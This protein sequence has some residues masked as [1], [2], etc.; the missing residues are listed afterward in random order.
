MRIGREDVGKGFYVYAFL[1][2]NGSPYYV[3][4]GRG[5]RAWNRA[6]QA[7]RRPPKDDSRILILKKSLTEEEAFKHERYMITVLGRKDLGTGILRNRTAG[8]EGTSG[9]IPSEETRAKIEEANRNRS[10]KARA[11]MSRALR[12]RR[13]GADH[14]AKIVKGLIAKGVPCGQESPQARAY[15]FTDPS[16]REFI[17][18]GRFDAFCRENGIA[19]RTMCGALRRNCT[20]PPRNGWLVRKAMEQSDLEVSVP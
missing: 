20:P 16:G 8:G 10:E 5:K 3:G 6:S 18:I 13:L 7:G 11:S 17:V 1:R 12:G 4:K 2:E 19:A 9:W 15:I 14:R